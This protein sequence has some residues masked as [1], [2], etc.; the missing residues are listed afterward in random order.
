[1][2]LRLPSHGAAA[3]LSDSEAAKLGVVHVPKCAGTAVQAA[4]S[5]LPVC[6]SGPV[7]YDEDHFG[8]LDPVR[9]LP[10]QRAATVATRGQ[11]REAVGGHRLVIG[12]FSAATLAAAGVRALAVAVREPVSRLLSLYRYWRSLPPDAAASWGEWGVNLMAAA[13]NLT[14]GEFLAAPVTWP[15]V[16]NQLARQ[17]LV[18]GRVRRVSAL[19]RRLRLTAFRYGYPS[20]RRRLVVAGWSGQAQSFVS[21]VCAAVGV[22]TPPLV[23]RVNVTRISPDADRQPITP[24]TR[25]LLDRLT[26]WD[27]ELVDRL[28][29]DGLLPG[30][31]PGDLAGELR[32][33]AERLGF[34][35]A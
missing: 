23:D 6:H 26:R 21:Q 35:L 14:L 5:A 19:H 29:A 13:T 33:T 11:L 17:L 2:N 27:R 28:M 9:Q 24:A 16:D 32:A 15:A 7:Y 4:L 20:L 25:V 34:E 3:E 22:T 31:G 12:H 18:D 8:W 1:V 30:R 10:P